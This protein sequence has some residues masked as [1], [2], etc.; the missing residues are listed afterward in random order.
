MG[1]VYVLQSRSKKKVFN[2]TLKGH[3]H[4]LCQNVLYISRQ[5]INKCTIAG[6]PS[7]TI[8]IITKGLSLQLYQIL[9]P[10][11]AIHVLPFSTKLRIIFFSEI[12]FKIYINKTQ[13]SKVLMS[14]QICLIYCKIYQKIRTLKF[15]F[16]QCE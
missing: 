11:E 4:I 8:C 14:L 12:T 15:L 6:K 5:V 2:Y 1:N 10:F 13:K 9:H 16:S 3:L 7:T